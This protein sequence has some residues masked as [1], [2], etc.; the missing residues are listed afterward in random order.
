[1]LQEL[2]EAFTVLSDAA[3]R[4]QYDQESF[5][6]SHVF[7]SAGTTDL[8]LYFLFIPRGRFK[9]H[10]LLTHIQTCGDQLRPFQE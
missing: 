4:K 3:Q 6:F 1:M 5:L 8:S 9:R 2:A 10:I 7:W